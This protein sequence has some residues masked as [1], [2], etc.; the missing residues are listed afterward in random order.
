MKPTEKMH[1]CQRTDLSHSRGIPFKLPP[2]VGWKQVV[3]EQ[4][5]S[6]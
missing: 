4:L 1:S 5:G 3:L 2:A 6:V